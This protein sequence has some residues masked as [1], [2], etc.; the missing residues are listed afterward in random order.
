MWKFLKSIIKSF[1][2]L[3]QAIWGV[4]TLGVQIIGGWKTVIIIIISIIIIV[5]IFCI[6]KRFA[7]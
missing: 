3:L 4:I 1:W 2:V 7:K 5:S 6:V